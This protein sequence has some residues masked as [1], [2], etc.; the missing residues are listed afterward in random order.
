MLAELD[1]IEGIHVEAREAR[2]TTLV[3][4]HWWSSPTGP[5]HRHFR[6]TWDMQLYEQTWR[7]WRGNRLRCHKAEALSLPRKQGT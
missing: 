6:P 2:I 1:T 4:C 3:T 5:R 7:K